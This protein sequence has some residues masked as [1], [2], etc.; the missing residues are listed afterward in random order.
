[1][2]ALNEAKARV[3]S[4][5][6]ERPLADMP[7]WQS[8]L[9]PLARLGVAVGRDLAHG[10]LTLRAMSL[11][12]TTLLAF[13]PLIAVS[14]SVLKGFGVHNQ[15]RPALLNVLSP[16]GERASEITDT[17]I[18][19]VENIQVGV[20][21]AIGMAFLLYTAI[22]LVQ[23]VEEAFNFTWNV[24]RSRSVLRKFSDYFSVLL[25]GPLLVFLALAISASLT[26]TQVVQAIMAVEPFGTLIRWGTRMVPY[27]LVIAAFTFL[28]MLIP[29]TRVRFAPA[30]FGATVAG[31]AWETVGHLFARF[32]V[33]STNYTAIYSGFAILLLFMIWLHLAWLI[34]LT[35]STIAFYRQHPEYLARGGRAAVGLSPAQQELLALAIAIRLARAFEDESEAPTRDTLARSLG[36]PM[37][38]ADQT[39]HALEE[40]G[41]VRMTRDDPPAW[42]PARPPARMMVK[43]VLDA[44]RNQGRQPRFLAGRPQGG[45]SR[46]MA[47]VEAALDRTIGQVSVADLLPPADDG[48]VATEGEASRETETGAT[49]S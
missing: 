11:V 39:L 27:A 41:L 48:T 9:V 32:V 26:S 45:E 38:T 29:N 12:F 5:L 3:E 25:I 15:L 6:W 21:G 46:V 34:L 43:G 18:D 28:Y 16:L 23:K 22:S 8:V 13:V 7:R 19:F 40:A 1:M 24:A 33:M 20:L 14:F 49:A 2:R 30:L 4:E 44:V 17:I 36:V 31:V 37:E 42:V 47:T 10:M 35:G